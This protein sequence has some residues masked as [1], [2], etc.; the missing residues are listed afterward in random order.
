MDKLEYLE[1]E[2]KKIW[3]KIIELEDDVKKK[4]SDYENEAKQAS[5]KASEYRNKS[6]TAKETALANLAIIETSKQ[7]LT[8][9]ELDANKKTNQIHDLHSQSILLSTQFNE[10]LKLLNNQKNILDEQ[11]QKLEE[12]FESEDDLELK[13]KKIEEAFL[14]TNEYSSKIGTA[15]KLAIEKKGEIDNIYD[16]IYGYEEKDENDETIIVKGL[17]DE[18]S[19]SYLDLKKGISD[20][21]GDL[22]ILKE[23]C[24]QKLNEFIENIKLKKEENITK[25]DNEFKL[26]YKKIQD[27]LPNALTAGLSHAY[28]SK[29]ENEVEEMK[30][31]SSTFRKAI[32][33]MVCI[34]LIPFIISIVQLKTMPL[35]EVLLELPRYVLS[36]LPLYIPALWVAYSASKKVNLSKRLIEEYTHKEVLSKTFE[37]LSAQIE[38]ISDTK[39]SEQLKNKLLFTILEVSSENPGKLISDYNKAD[40][41]LMDALEKSEK[42]G[43]AIE[44]LQKIPGVSSL[45]SLLEKTKSSILEDKITKTNIGLEALSKNHINDV[46]KEF[47]E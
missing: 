6:E 7:K 22:T 10:E 39:I 32:W 21:N 26:I 15:H 34:S 17:K 45:S 13:I 9:L 33:G 30:T 47:Q 1:D 37:G 12:I 27:L 35:K 38:S 23:E 8:E 19:S 25:W 36:I 31:L 28:S 44:K 46:T 5:K 2:R 18:L 16:E 11:I 41:P 40:H 43:S 42:L 4:S 14:K 29:K 24:I 20:L 3:K